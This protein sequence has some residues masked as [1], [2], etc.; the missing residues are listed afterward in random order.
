M[1]ADAKAT[2][3]GR[4]REAETTL[5]PILPFAHELGVGNVEVAYD[6]QRLNVAH[7]RA[8]G[9]R[10]IGRKIGLTSKMVQRQLGVDQP[11]YG[12]LFSDMEIGHGESI[13]RDQFIA[14]RVEAEIAL[15]LDRD[16]TDAD[17]SIAELMRAIAFATPALEIVDS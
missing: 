7:W 3:A 14:P 2:V 16:I 10:K 6:V 12:T 13:Q 5:R 1:S 11:D 8:N 15:V 4:L 9:R 17:V